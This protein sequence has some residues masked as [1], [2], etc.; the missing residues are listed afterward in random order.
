MLCLISRAARVHSGPLALVVCT[1]PC[2]AGLGD[3]A[4]G[5]AAKVAR[6]RA[7]LRGGWGLLAK[8]GRRLAPGQLFGAPARPTKPGNRSSPFSACAGGSSVMALG[9]L[10]ALRR[11]DMSREVRARSLHISDVHPSLSRV[12]A[13]CRRSANCD[14][15]FLGVQTSHLRV[16]GAPTWVVSRRRSASQTGKI[17]SDVQPGAGAASTSS[18]SGCR[19]H[20]AIWAMSAHG[21]SVVGVSC[22]AREKRKC[23]VA[24]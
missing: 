22:R 7:P 19:V 1:S 15:I 3:L 23:G 24:L 18:I 8:S 13:V 4:R 17:P 20:V 9:R 6:L 2:A 16:V 12:R 11:S 21:A 14:R 5:Q 10:W